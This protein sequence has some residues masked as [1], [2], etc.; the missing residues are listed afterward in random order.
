MIKREKPWGYE[1]ILIPS[2]FPFT[3]KLAF[4]KAN[5]RWSLQYHE[6][7][8]EIII[9]VSGKAVLS[10]ENSEG[11]LIEKRMCFLKPFFISRLEK[12]RFCAKT[13]CWTLEFSTPEKGKTVRLK[14]DYQRGDETE[15]ERLNNLL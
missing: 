8:K 9:L 6:Q 13:N 3:V 15:T 12:H 14:D 11:R 7:K 4:S 2:W 10:E 5:T 1:L